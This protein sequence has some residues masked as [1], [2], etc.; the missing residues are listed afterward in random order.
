VQH[1]VDGWTG[2]AVS[3]AALA[4]VF[5]GLL[6]AIAAAASAIWFAVQIYESRTFQHWNRN[7]QMRSRAKKLARLRAREKITLAQIAAIER[8]RHARSDAKDIVAE[9]KAAAAALLVSQDTAA[10]E[11]LPPV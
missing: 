10:E 5:A 2:H 6:P 1:Y 4:A 3:L 9:A 7:R 11:K 8:V